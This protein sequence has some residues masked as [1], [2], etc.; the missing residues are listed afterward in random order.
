MKRKL[1]YDL[2]RVAAGLCAV[3]MISSVMPSQ[4]MSS[5][6]TA[7][8]M[9]EESIDEKEYYDISSVDDLLWAKQQIESRN[10]GIN[11]ILKN[12]IDLSGTQW[13]SIGKTGAADYGE[14][15][16]YVLN[17]TFDGNG[18]TISGI[19]ASGRNCS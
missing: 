16:A 7:I 10:T 4:L 5:A 18:H 2:R 17:G 1:S 8:V 6:F 3:P 14:S 12:D 11:L 15:G 9:A 13:T 19:S